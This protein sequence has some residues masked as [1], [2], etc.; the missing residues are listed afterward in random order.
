MSMFTKRRKVVRQKQEEDRKRWKEN[1]K[2]LD[3]S[4]NDILKTCN[5]IKEHHPEFESLD[6]DSRVKLFGKTLNKIH[7]DT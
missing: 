6:S 5:Y 1:S 7:N 4:M 2:Q 3:K